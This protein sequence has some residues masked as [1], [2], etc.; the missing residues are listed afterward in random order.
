LFHD[1]LP[2]LSLI[3][4]PPPSTAG[5]VYVTPLSFM[6]PSGMFGDARMSLKAIL[7]LDFGQ[8]L[9][10]ARWAVEVDLRV[11]SVGPGDS[12]VY[13]VPRRRVADDPYDHVPIA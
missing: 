3:R 5:Y 8:E 7:A 2:E 11:V 10:I 6:M 9:V 1:R 12:C 13:F 4:A